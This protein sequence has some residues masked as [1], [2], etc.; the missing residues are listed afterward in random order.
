M[1]EIGYALSS[2]EFGPTD[3]VRFAEHAERAGFDFLGIS[4]HFHP[5]TDRQGHSPLVWATLGGVAQVTESVTVA[6][7]VTC[8]TTRLHPAVVAQ[9]AATVAAMMPGRFM[10]GLGAGENLNEHIVGRGW[11]E[12][13][14]RL[15]QLE[16]TV[17]V[18]RA[19]WEGGIYSHRGPHFTVE[20]ARIYTLPAEPPPILLAAGGPGATRLAGNIGDGMFGLAPDADLIARFDEAG[21]AGKPKIGQLH[22]CWAPDEQRARRTALDHWPNAGL[23]TALNWELRLPSDFEAAT[24]AVTEDDVARSVV[25][26]PDP[27][28]YVDAVR[29]FLQ[30]GYTHVYLHQVGPE[31]GPFIELAERELLPALR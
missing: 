17:E 2:E 23:P 15:E 8:P 22:V 28:R 11:P 29:E 6:T 26:G 9:A 10:L 27:Q 21:G 5:W 14:V 18:I 30:A 24:Q 4:D 20:Q 19:L 31:Q 13:A 16:E 7:G 12:P 25:C 1:P 3:L